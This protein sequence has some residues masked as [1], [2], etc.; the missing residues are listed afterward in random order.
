MVSFDLILDIKTDLRL[1]VMR[2]GDLFEIKFLPRWLLYFF[3]ITSL[4]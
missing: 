1:A 3:V 4:I 2:S